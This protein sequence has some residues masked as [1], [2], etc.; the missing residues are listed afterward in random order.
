VI[1]QPGAAPATGGVL[2]NL[3]PI[4]P[5]LLCEMANWRQAWKPALTD[6]RLAARGSSMQET[7]RSSNRAFTLIEL[8]IVIG[9]I[10]ILALIALPNMLEAQMRAKVSRARSD[11]RSLATA[12]ESYAV[13]ANHYPPQ[14]NDDVVSERFT[15]PIAYI[16]SIPNDPFRTK[17]QVGRERRFGYHNVRQQVDNHVPSWPEADLKRYGDWRFFS[18]G[19]EQDYRPHIPYDATNGTVSWGNILRTQRSPEG[20][21]LYTYW[22]PANPDV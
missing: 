20:N 6:L 16:T 22:D 11:M 15:T 8:L 10:A 21:I 17:G 7:T 4:R 12:L 1:S 14:E 2:T 18:Y 13:D 3:N 5:Y 19:P 9:I